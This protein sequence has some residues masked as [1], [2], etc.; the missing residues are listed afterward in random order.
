MGHDS[1]LVGCI[2]RSPSSD[3]LQS[4]IGLCKLLTEIGD[5]THLLICGDFLTILTLTGHQILVVIIVHNCFLTL[6]KAST[7]S[8]M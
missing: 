4:T 2:Y 7:F 6:Y 1:L 5:H 3:T 8:S